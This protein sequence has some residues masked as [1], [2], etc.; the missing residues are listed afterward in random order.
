MPIPIP[1]CLSLCGYE[2]LF[3]KRSKLHVLGLLY[4]PFRQPMSMGDPLIS[5]SPSFLSLTDFV[6][7]AANESASA[8]I[9]NISRLCAAV[10]NKP[11]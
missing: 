8:V 9:N 10:D 11:T 5:A 7:A 1:E 3:A 6:A 2:S 4:D